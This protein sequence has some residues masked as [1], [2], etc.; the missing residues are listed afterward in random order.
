MS[1]ANFNIILTKAEF[2][3]LINIRNKTGPRTPL[4]T[5]LQ[6]D[7]QPLMQILCFL[8]YSGGPDAMRQWG[9]QAPGP[10]ACRALL[11]FV[12]HL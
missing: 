4:L 9:P 1:S 3:S 7:L 5:I 10:S 6:E 2:K 11:A 8:P 12:C